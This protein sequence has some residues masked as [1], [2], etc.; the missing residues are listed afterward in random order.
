MVLL[1]TGMDVLKQE[2]TENCLV[3]V[4]HLDSMPPVLM[5]K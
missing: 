5:E 2:F 1:Q 4:R 3:F